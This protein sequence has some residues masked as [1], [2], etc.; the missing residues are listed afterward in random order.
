MIT[1]GSGYKKDLGFATTICSC[2]VGKE[3]VEKIP[4]KIRCRFNMVPS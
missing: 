1:E 3:A 4:V 2:K